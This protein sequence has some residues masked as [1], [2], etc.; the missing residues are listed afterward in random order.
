MSLL[1]TIQLLFALLLAGLLHACGGGGGGSPAPASAPSPVH[2]QQTTNAVVSNWAIGDLNGD[3]LDDVVIGGW[4]GIN[5][6]KTTFRILIQ[7]NDGTLTDQTSQ[8]VSNNLYDGSQRIFIADFDRDGRNDIWLPGFNDCTNCAA[9]SVM[10]WNA[11]TQFTRDEFSDGL[12][13][14]G[15][16]VT[17]LN[18]DGYLDMVV[19]GFYV[20]GR[21]TSGYYL[22]NRNNLNRSFSF[23][24]SS[25]IMAGAACALTPTPIAGQ[26]AMVQA[27][28]NQMPGFSS[29]I[30]VLDS[31]LNVVNRIG[32][33]SSSTLATDL[34]GVTSLDMN[35]DGFDD[36]VLVF[37][38]YVPGVPGVKDVWLN[39]GHNGF[40]YA[41]TLDSDTN[42]Q[43]SIHHTT[44]AGTRYLM[45]DAPNGDAR[46]YKQISNNWAA[47]G[48][49][50]FAS[51]ARQLG[52]RPGVPD[53]SIGMGAIYTNP[54][55]SAIYMLQNVGGVYY[56]ARLR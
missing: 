5:G 30:A 47:F 53:W 55:A 11:G 19:Q 39:D 56:T 15:A 17:D 54:Q 20:W 40:A 34:I 33:T 49:E 27:N 26:R 45:F 31:A 10:L 14:H 43:Y 21:Q 41:Y 18:G 16:C 29:H 23:V 51:M 48:T 25:D 52:G 6:V 38:D 32:I 1:R 12:E 4:T 13:S 24:T 7:N 44:V 37:N 46:L 22:N 3:G 35:Q 2:N 50:S 9:N 42:N 8:W 36:F 28:V